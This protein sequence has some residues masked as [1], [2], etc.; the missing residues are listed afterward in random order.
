MGFS[1]DNLHLFKRLIKSSSGIITITGPVNSGK[2]TLLYSVL[3][4]LNTQNV[5]IVDD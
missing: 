5:N 2:S 1:V 4:Y 3:N